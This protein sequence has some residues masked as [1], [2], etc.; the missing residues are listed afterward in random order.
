[1]ANAWSPARC[2]MSP[3]AAP[4]SRSSG[5]RT[6]KAGPSHCSSNLIDSE[7]PVVTVT[8]SDSPIGGLFVVPLPPF[9]LS[10]RLP[11]FVG[12]PV[13]DMREERGTSRSVP[14]GLDLRTV[15]GDV[16]ST[17]CPST[18]RSGILAIPVDDMIIGLLLRSY[19]HSI[20]SN[21]KTGNDVS[22]VSLH[23]LEH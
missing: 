4:S 16:P 2:G 21:G 10:G 12:V 1:M 15:R 14:V 18:R 7:F 8:P 3:L 23:L 13:A 6:A 5:R 20:T 11:V 9:R 17:L 19:A 22:N